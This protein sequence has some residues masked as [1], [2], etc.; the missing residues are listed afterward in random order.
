M[1]D[2][3]DRLYDRVLVLRCQAGDGAAF[4][5]LIGRYSALVN[6]T[7]RRLL[8]GATDDVAQDVW[9]A[10]WRGLPKLSDPAALPAWVRR[11]ARDRAFQELRRR[12]RRVTTLPLAVEPPAT[13]PDDPA[14]TD[15]IRKAVDR[16]PAVHRDVLALRFLEGLSYEQTA[17]VLGCPVGT[18]RSRLHHAKA[19]LRGLLTPEDD[20]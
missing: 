16:L 18:V 9:L 5:E 6:G 14:D 8:G 20:R 15:R 12:N 2:D 10:V 7:L 11:V 3:L 13:E 1:S 17:A 4:A 19:A